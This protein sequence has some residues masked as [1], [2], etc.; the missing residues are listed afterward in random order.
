MIEALTHR[1]IRFI[2]AHNDRKHVS[3]A[4]MAFALQSLLT[5]VFTIV[6]SLL[7]AAFLGTFKETALALLAVAVLRNLTG[8]LHFKSATVCVVV[9]TLVVVLIPFIPIDHM[10]G[11]VLT[12]VSAIL[13]LLFAPS[14]LKG[15]T[16]ISDRGLQIMKM[17]G[18]LLVSSNLALQSPLLALSFFSVGLTL[19]PW[20]GGTKHA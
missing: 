9:S 8:G 18:L 7:I 4:V 10:I 11:M 12:V 1:I 3:S 14:D 20:K 6:L 13:V 2:E 17:A 15:K 16:R 5:N 19:V